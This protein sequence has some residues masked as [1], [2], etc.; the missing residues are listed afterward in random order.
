METIK[1]TKVVAEIMAKLITL[2]NGQFVGFSNYTNNYGEVANHVVNV[3]FD[4]YKAKRKDIDKL[5]N[6]TNN[7]IID[8]VDNINK[9]EYFLNEPT[10][11]SE[12]NS[13][14]AGML[15]NYA[16]PSKRN[17]EDV[18]THI[19][20]TSLKVHNLTGEIH[21]YSLAV[22]KTVLVE[23]N[24]APKNSYRKTRLEDA[25]K[26]HLNFTTI[27]FRQFKLVADKIVQVKLGGD[28]FIFE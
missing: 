4:Y 13:T 10:S 18:Y 2:P 1:I 26:K 3:K 16:K 23:G 12:I 20:G 27:K 9:N 6:I 7:D 28:A 11:S 22:Q 5:N 24:Y 14:I 25:I 19:E 8:I 21:A 17:K 15:A